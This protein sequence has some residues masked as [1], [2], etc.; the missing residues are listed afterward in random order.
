MTRLNFFW[1]GPITA[2]IIAG[3]AIARERHVASH[4]LVVDRYGTGDTYAGTATN[5]PSCI[6]APRVGAFATEPWTNSSMRAL[7][8]ILL[9]KRVQRIKTASNLRSTQMQI[10]TCDIRHSRAICFSLHVREAD[11]RLASSRPGMS[12]FSSRQR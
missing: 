11:K 9:E 3:P 5:A 7:F 4:H 10:I 1:A 12:S 8:R 6:Y 2:V